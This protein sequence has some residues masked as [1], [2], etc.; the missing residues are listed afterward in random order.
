MRKTRRLLS[1][2]KGF[3]CDKRKILILVFILGLLASDITAV[4]CKTIAEGTFCSTLLILLLLPGV[5]ATF[6]KYIFKK[7]DFR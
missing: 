5:L 1:V 6:D 3:I 2:V 7:K 4:I